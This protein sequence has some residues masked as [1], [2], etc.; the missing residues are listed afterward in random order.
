MDYTTL[1]KTA[2]TYR[3]A[4][5]TE[6]L[7][8]GGRVH[9]IE[10][11]FRILSA[12]GFFAWMILFFGATLPIFINMSPVFSSFGAEYFSFAKFSFFILLGL[13]IIFALGYGFFAS[14]YFRDA[15]TILPEW[16]LRTPSLRFEVA[17]VVSE[18]L[19]EP[20]LDFFS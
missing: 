11:I 5:K 12:L 14:S 10:K 19:Q 8:S 6:A 2:A 7:I 4:L 17:R 15:D 3:E 1:Q 20:V 9:L 16:K 13:W 18:G